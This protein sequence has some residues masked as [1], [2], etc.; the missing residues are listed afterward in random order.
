MDRPFQA[1]IG[2]TITAVSVD[3]HSRTKTVQAWSSVSF[4]TKVTPPPPPPFRRAKLNIFAAVS[5]ASSNP[6]APDPVSDLNR[7]AVGLN[8]IGYDSDSKCR[9]GDWAAGSKYALPS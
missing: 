4:L 2:I 7:I 6:P 1:S 3:A 5:C 8:P 9:G